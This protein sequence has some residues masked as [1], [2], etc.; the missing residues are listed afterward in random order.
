[1]WSCIML[2]YVWSFLSRPDGELFVYRIIMGDHFSVYPVSS[3]SDDPKGKSKLTN[4]N[5]R[6]FFN[7]LVWLL[8]AAMLM[9]SELFEKNSYTG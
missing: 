2:I 4:A 6:F 7:H 5:E 3:S 9:W 1:M 8:W